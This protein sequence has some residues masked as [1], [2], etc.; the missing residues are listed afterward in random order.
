MKK[1]MFALTALFVA[2]ALWGSLVL[3]GMSPASAAPLPADEACAHAIP[4]AQA[5]LPFN[6]CVQRPSP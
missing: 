5:G 4:N 6:T 2:T 1:L 3:A